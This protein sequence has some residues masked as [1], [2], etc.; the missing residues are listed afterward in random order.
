MQKVNIIHLSDI[1]YNNTENMNNLID[2]LQVDL[3]KMKQELNE[4]HLLL[5]TGDCI[6][7]GN[8]N[9]FDDFGKKLN[10]IIKECGI[11]KKKVVIS[12]GNHDANLHSLM[13]N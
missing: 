10:K 11:S 12:I 3:L 6:D 5:I 1:H 8:V 13:E 2:N 7:K 9:L 4:F